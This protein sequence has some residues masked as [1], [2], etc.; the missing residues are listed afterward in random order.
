MKYGSWVVMTFSYGDTALKF[1]HNLQPPSSRQNTPPN[2]L[3]MEAASSSKTFVPNKHTVLSQKTV[4]GQ[5]TYFNF[6]RCLTLLCFPSIPLFVHYCF[7]SLSFFPSSPFP[8]F[9]IYFSTRLR[10]RPMSKTISLYKGADK[11]LA[12]PGRKR[13]NVSVRMA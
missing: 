10:L 3:N 6:P 7:L 2:T 9:H 12:R 4:T 8:F 5:H 1:R 11:F 13:A